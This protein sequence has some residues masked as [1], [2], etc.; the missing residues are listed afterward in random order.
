MTGFVKISFA[1]G[2][3]AKERDRRTDRRTDP[4]TDGWEPDNL[5]PPRTSISGG[6]LKTETA[7]CAM[8]GAIKFHNETTDAAFLLREQLC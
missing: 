4:H 2:Y 5:M 8:F 1:R 6:G 7:I 3:K